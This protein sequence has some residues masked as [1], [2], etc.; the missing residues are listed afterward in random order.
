[1]CTI[2]VIHGQQYLDHRKTAATGLPHWHDAPPRIDDETKVLH[3]SHNFSAAA[4]TAAGGGARLDRTR[5]NVV[6]CAIQNPDYA[7]IWY[8]DAALDA[9]LDEAAAI[10][11]RIS[12]AVAAL[13]RPRNISSCARTSRGCCSST[14]TAAGGSTRTRSAST[15]SRLFASTAAS[16]RGRAR[17][18][19]SP[20]RRSTGRSP[21]RRAT[22]FRCTPRCSPRTASRRFLGTLRHARANEERT[23]R[24]GQYRC[25][26][27]PA[28]Q[29]SATHYKRTPGLRRTARCAR[30]LASEPTTRPP[31]RGRRR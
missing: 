8:D 18:P 20:R 22:S 2:T 7:T 27:L 24:A 17:S 12:R 15:L 25:S 19:T 21:A 10:D 29:C 11:K 4:L 16:S 6:S 13:R 14:R 1:M 31:G 23:A 26:T 28:P 5:R 3:R 9:F 30:R